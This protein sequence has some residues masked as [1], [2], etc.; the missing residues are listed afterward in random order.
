MYFVFCF[1]NIY[2]NLVE[3]TIVLLLG[4]LSLDPT[5]PP[6][7]LTMALVQISRLL[8]YPRIFLGLGVA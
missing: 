8:P 7:A 1:I 6:N 3:E 4:I 2:S 5:L